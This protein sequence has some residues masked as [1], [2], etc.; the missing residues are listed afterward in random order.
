MHL[1]VQGAGEVEWGVIA[2]FLAAL[3]CM[4]ARLRINSTP[5]VMDL[6]RNLAK[7]EPPYVGRTT[8]T[9]FASSQ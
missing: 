5:I 3:V 1:D 8:D 7:G 2:E 4:G 9:S 6:N